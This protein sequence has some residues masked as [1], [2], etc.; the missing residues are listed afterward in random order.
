MTS[1]SLFFLSFVLN[2]H[3]S[4]CVTDLPWG[5]F[6]VSGY[7]LNRCTFTSSIV[8][9][10]TKHF[11]W[12]TK[13]C[14]EL[15]LQTITGTIKTNAIWGLALCQAVCRTHYVHY[16]TYSSHTHTTRVLLLPSFN[17]EETKAWRGHAASKGLSWNWNILIPKPIAFNGR[18]HKNVPFVR[19]EAWATVPRQIPFRVA[20]P[21]VKLNLLLKKL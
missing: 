21:V 4:V 20:F 6:C 14:S 13:L 12:K 15:Q 9:Q 1:L 17:S 11:T 5:W 16:F 19:N 10:Q 7:H 3:I 18:F 8:S 2:N